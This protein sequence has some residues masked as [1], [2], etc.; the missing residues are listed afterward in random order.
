MKSSIHDYLDDGVQPSELFFKVMEAAFD[1]ARIQFGVQGAI[2]AETSPRHCYYRLDFGPDY[3]PPSPFFRRFSGACLSLLSLPN[4]TR[5]RVVLD[6]RT[7]RP[8]QE[9]QARRAA[10]VRL[11][12]NE[13]ELARRLENI[14]DVILE[15]DTSGQLA[16]VSPNTLLKLGYQPTELKMDP[17][18]IFPA[19]HKLNVSELLSRSPGVSEGD[20]E[21]EHETIDLVMLDLMMPK[22]NGFQVLTAMRN[23]RPDLPA[24]LVTGLGEDLERAPHQLIG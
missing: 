2:V 17:L 15:F 21:Q 11:N 1:Q 16:Y 10:E 4:L 6:S 13:G 9:L 18:A 22:L 5:I 8:E 3:K 12:K 7:L 23:I 20:T 19:E 14:H 24:L